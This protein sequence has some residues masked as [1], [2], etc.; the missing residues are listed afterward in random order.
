M[1]LSSYSFMYHGGVKINH[2]GTC[3]CMYAEL[4]MLVTLLS[5]ENFHILLYSTTLVLFC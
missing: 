3:V 1:Y 5:G 2:R 4:S